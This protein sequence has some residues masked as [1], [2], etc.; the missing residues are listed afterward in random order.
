MILSGLV[1]I[2]VYAANGKVVSFRDLASGDIFGEL[3]AIDGLPRSANAEALAATRVGVLTPQAF[4]HKF[5]SEPQF[6]SKLVEQM[7]ANIRLLSERLFELS[8]LGIQVRV[9]AEILRMAKEAGVRGNQAVIDPASK[10]ADMAS[11]IGVNREQVTKELSIMARE[12]LVL[13]Q[14]RTLIVPD[15]ARLEFIVRNG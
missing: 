9:R 13:K 4:W 11:R 5:E 15:V 12:G 8:T 1:R 14:G 10:H 2:S 3:S 6:R 7:A